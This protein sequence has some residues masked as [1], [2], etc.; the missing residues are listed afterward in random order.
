MIHKSQIFF[1]KI[2]TIILIYLLAP[3]IVQNLKKILPVGPELWE[4]YGPKMA[5]FPK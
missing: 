4:I 1:W 5:Y 3:F 2:I